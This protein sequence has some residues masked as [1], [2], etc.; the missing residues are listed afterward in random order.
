MNRI[1]S[2]HGLLPNQTFVAPDSKKFYLR[3]G[4]RHEASIHRRPPGNC[5]GAYDNQGYYIGN[6]YLVIFYLLIGPDTNAS[7]RGLLMG[8]TFA[9]VH[10]TTNLQDGNYYLRVF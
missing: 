7:A 5:H 4:T 6:F 8:K 1:S 3:A 10:M 9:M 2:V